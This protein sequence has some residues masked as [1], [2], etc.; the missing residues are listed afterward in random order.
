MTDKKISLL[1]EFDAKD[2]IY[3]VSQETMNFEEYL[4]LSLQNPNVLRTSSQRLYDTIMKY[5]IEKSTNVGNEKLPRY[6]IFNDP[7]D[8]GKNAIFG[9]DD[10]LAGLVSFIKSSALGY[11]TKKRFLLLYGPVGTA[12]SSA[13][14]ILKRGLSEYSKT[15]EGALYIPEWYNIPPTE[16]EK[17]FKEEN[18][19]ECPL[20]EDPIFLLPEEI[21]M[22][23]LSRIKDPKW[24]IMDLKGESCP[25]CRHL[26]ERLMKEYDGDWKK[27]L[28]EHVRIKRMVLH[29]KTRKGIGTFK[30]NDE[31]NQDS[32]EL[33]GETNFVRL[34]IHGDETH[35]LAFAHRGEFQVA[36]R[37]ILEI[38]EVLKLNQQFLYQFLDAT[39]DEVIK[40]KNQPNIQIDS[41][42]LGHTNPYEFQILIQNQSMEAFTDRMIKVD[43]GYNTQLSEEIKIY[44]KGYSTGKLNKHM[45]PHTK[46]LIAMFA[47]LTRLIEPAKIQISLMDKL[48]LYDGRI[49]ENHNL[50]TIRKLQREG[51]S[52]SSSLKE[53]FF[54]LSP[55]FGQNLLSNLLCHPNYPEECVNPFHLFLELEHQI[56]NTTTIKSEK[57]RE[58]YLEKLVVLIKDEYD[59]IARNE[60]RLAS[61]SNNEEIDSL[62]RQYR[63]N[64]GAFCAKD[65]VE[66]SFGELIEPDEELM[67][68][69]EQR[70]GNEEST[71]ESFRHGI[72]ARI[73]RL[74]QQG[75][76]FGAKS[77]EKLYKA[78]E[79]EI[80]SRH[81]NDINIAAYSAKT[82]SPE[83]RKKFNSII[84]NLI[85][86]QGYCE[87]C[88][89]ALMLYASK[90]LKDDD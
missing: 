42:L 36:N 71:T 5:E 78:L 37:G 68:K 39:Q 38:V 51:K 7:F 41:I 34:P 30:P 23:M 89:K 64:L 1:D 84:K 29:E 9:I 33:T 4:Q 69:I 25:V 56:K 62:F 27:V 22:Q 90:K 19:Y 88:A 79:E 54:G 86:K 83:E 18:K 59:T 73:A 16:R 76:E 67:R 77:D 70:L 35:P 8:N 57:D 45:A 72:N 53:T 12:K 47:L 21:R 65:K 43:I 48:K 52:I 81:K 87:H 82:I 13:I 40:P 14:N 17:E 55:R 20:K 15:A 74:H 11:D 63:D 28:T 44:N 3:D 46:E 32:T 26:Y 80:Y 24:N 58:F 49:V 75:K 31:K 50:E 85:E 10:A 60:L 66:D 2:E 61:I 6:Q